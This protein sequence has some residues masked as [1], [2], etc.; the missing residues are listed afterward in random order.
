LTSLG[1]LWLVSAD[2]K[3]SHGH[4]IDVRLIIIVVIFRPLT[5]PVTLLGPLLLLLLRVLCCPKAL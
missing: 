4:V 2:V 3:V 5:I 1:A